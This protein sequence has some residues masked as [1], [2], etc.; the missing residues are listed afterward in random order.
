MKPFKV[1]VKTGP[2]A[3]RWVFVWARNEI[4]ARIK[5]LKQNKYAGECVAALEL[6]NEPRKP[7]EAFA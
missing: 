2:N 6:G 4:T 5:A 7:F 3:A 1:K